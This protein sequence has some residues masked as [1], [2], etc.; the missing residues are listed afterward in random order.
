MGERPSE[1]ERRSHGALNVA[2]V[3]CI[4]GVVIVI[5][6]HEVVGGATDLCIHVLV[7]SLPRCRLAPPIPAP[8]RL[9]QRIERLGTHDGVVEK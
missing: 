7:A 3:A 1:V 8:A 5:S 9:G 4:T 2:F 6:A